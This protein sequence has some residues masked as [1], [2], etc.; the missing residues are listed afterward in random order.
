MSE[1]KVSFPA[2]SA[3]FI[4]DLY[5]R[6]IRDPQSVHPGWKP[7]FDDLYGR[8]ADEVPVVEP[9]LEAAVARLMRPIGSVAISPPGSIL[10]D[11][12]RRRAPADLAPAAQG[13]ATASLDAALD[14]DGVLGL[15]RCI[16]REVVA[17]LSEVTIGSP[18]S[19]YAVLGF[20]YGLSLDSPKNLVAW[21]A[22]F[23]D[24]ANVEQVIIDQFVASGQDKWLDGSG[25]VLLL[26]HGLEGQRP[27]IPP[28]GSNGSCNFAPTITARHR[29]TSFISCGDR[30]ALRSAARWSCSPRSRCCG[31]S[32]RCPIS[33]TLL[34]APCLCR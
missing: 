13:I 25:L 15:N 28:D 29:R 31:T 22:Q 18:L 6:Y 17:R 4:I 2:V 7:Y 20:E 10:S 16:V 27:T 26:P 14:L 8:P 24:F 11:Y 9:G 3:D 33:T 32:M 23:G 30:R 21:E 1:S 12:G 19:E 34:S 5:H